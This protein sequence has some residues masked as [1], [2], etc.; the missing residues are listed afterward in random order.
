MTPRQAYDMLLE[1]GELTIMYEEF[2]FTGEWKKDRELF[3]K[4]HEQNEKAIEDAAG[5]IVDLDDDE[6]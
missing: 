6:Q 1:T 3:L 4:V 5:Y 2:D